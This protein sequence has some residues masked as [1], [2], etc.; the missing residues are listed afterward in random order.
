MK[1]YECKYCG[2][3]V[4]ESRMDVYVLRLGLCEHCYYT[5]RELE[6][7]EARLDELCYDDVLDED[8]VKLM[9]SA[10]A[11]VVAVLEKFFKVTE[12]L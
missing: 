2:K 7:V 5:K 11:D 10:R 4:T 1:T 6:D 3:E 9:Q 12:K 8:D